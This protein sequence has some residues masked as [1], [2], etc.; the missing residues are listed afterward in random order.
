[1]RRLHFFSLVAVLNLFVLMQAHRQIQTN[2]NNASTD[3]AIAEFFLSNRTVT[4]VDT[5][6][7]SVARSR[8][9]PDTPTTSATAFGPV[10][11]C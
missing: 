1:M 7:A 3:L 9:G 10:A 6:F 4:T 11:P 8:V 5:W 2:K